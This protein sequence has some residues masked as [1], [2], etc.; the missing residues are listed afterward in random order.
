MRSRISAGVRCRPAA[1]PA[2]EL[3]VEIGIERL[4][5][6]A[7]RRRE[8]VLGE[9]VRRRLVVADVERIRERAELVERAAQE[10]L[11]V[12][13]AGEVERRRRHEEDLVAGARQ[14][15]RLVAAVLEEGDDRLL[16]SLEVDDGVAHFL[17]LAPERGVAGR[18]DD[19]ARH[20]PI[21]GSPCAARRRSS[22]RSAARSRNC[23]EDTARFGF[24]EV[25][26]DLEQQRRVGRDLRSPPPTAR[27]RKSSPAAEM[28]TATRMSTSTTT[29]PRLTATEAS[30]DRV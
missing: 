10:E 27:P 8:R 17:H 24:L 12:R 25:A 28:A 26:A 18:P 7:V 16:R 15:V 13:H 11:V 21:D 5:H 2:I 19:D 1:R 6:L 14:V 3:F 23:T 9:G 22:A 30:C 4:G 20:A 29:T